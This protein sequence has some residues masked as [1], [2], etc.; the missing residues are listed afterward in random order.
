MDRATGRVRSDFLSTIVGRV[1][2]RRVGSGR[3]QEKW[4]LENSVQNAISC[5]DLQRCIWNKN[6]SVR[7]LHNHNTWI[8]FTSIIISNILIYS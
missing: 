5:K 1:N 8:T 4:P 6:A 2:V 3:V 7:I